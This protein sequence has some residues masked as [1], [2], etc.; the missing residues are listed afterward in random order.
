MALG[1]GGVGVGRAT[2]EMTVDLKMMTGMFHG[3]D[4]GCCSKKF[5]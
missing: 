5:I 2:P 3:L 4:L 1:V